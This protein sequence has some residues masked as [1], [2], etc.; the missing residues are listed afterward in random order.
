MKTFI[1][2]GQPK[3]A[4]TSIQSYMQTHRAVLAEHGIWVPSNKLAGSTELNHAVL[5]VYSLNKDNFSPAKERFFKH[6]KDDG[7]KF[8]DSLHTDLLNDIEKIYSDA[9]HNMCDKVLWSSEPLYFQNSAAEYKRLIA[10]FR[11]HST[12][13]NVIL[14]L[15]D[16]ESFRTSLIHQLRSMGHFPSSDP[17]S[18]KYW[19]PDSWLFDYKRKKNLLA[20]SFDN[21]LYFDYN[22]IDNLTPFFNTIGYNYPVHATNLRINITKKKS[23]P[24]LLP[25]ISVIKRLK[26]R[27]RIKSILINLKY[28]IK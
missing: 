2:I 5:N 9:R 20:D 3:T 21:C 13:I 15:R 22:P 24:S 12:E 4:T 28:V 14:C 7:Q 17:D 27:T 19:K 26:I 11:K 8:L 18:F 6:I 23:H 10:L 16:I 25:L 1:H